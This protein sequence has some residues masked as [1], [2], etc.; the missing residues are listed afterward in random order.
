[1]SGVYLRNK[2]PSTGSL[3]GML[4]R[5]GVPLPNI[6]DIIAR[7]QQN[8]TALS[9]REIMKKYKIPVKIPT[10]MRGIT[11]KGVPK[12]K[13]AQSG[14]NY[15]V[16]RSQY[17]RTMKNEN[18]RLWNSLSDVE[19]KN[20]IK[21][22]WSKAR[23]SSY[24][25]S[26]GEGMIAIGDG[27]LLS[28]GEGEGDGGVFYAGEGRRYAGDGGVF[29]AGRKP[30]RRS[31]TRRAPATRARAGIKAPAKRAP[32]RRTQVRKRAPVAGVRRATRRVARRAPARR[33]AGRAP[34][35]RTVRRTVVRR[36][37]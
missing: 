23:S 3:R 30:A 25:P 13:R 7:E 16:W 1:M 20:A 33:V 4:L 19:K 24:T 27:G 8:P 36:R 10:K 15:V 5:R 28:Y 14:L 2:K 9:P 37:R 35:R 29:Y 18:P 6:M 12:S 11:M 31:M 21:S 17:I 22:E 34:A 26:R 32:V